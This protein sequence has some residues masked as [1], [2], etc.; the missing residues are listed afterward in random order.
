MKIKI[1]A[2]VPW[3]NIVDYA[4]SLVRDGTLR[5][6]AKGCIWRNYVCSKNG[7]KKIKPR[8]AETRTKKG[9]LT[10]VLGVPGAR[11][12]RSMFAH[13]LVWIAYNGPIPDGLQI[14]HKD[15]NKANNCLSNLEVVSPSENIQHSYK[16]GRAK[17]WHKA[18]EWRPGILRITN[19]QKT[20]VIEL[21][22]SGHTYRSIHAL[23][24][25]S[26]A[27]IGRILKGGRVEN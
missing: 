13:R 15:L 6:D 25:I 16:N 23:T 9:Y 11:Q 12:T 17:P 3:L 26:Q 8:R 18:T 20:E 2:I 4:C 22:Q 14:N 27:H 21:R 10:I 1:K 24:K 19:A 7:R 5:I